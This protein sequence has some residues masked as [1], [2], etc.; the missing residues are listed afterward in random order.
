MSDPTS[1]HGVDVPPELA[2]FLWSQEYV[3]LLHA[4]NHG[5]VLVVKMPR[6]EIASVRGRVP[7]EVRQELYSHPAAPVIR[8]VTR[9]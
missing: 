2:E 8:L 4:T 3:A 9:I 1:Q 6:H 7:I 5:T